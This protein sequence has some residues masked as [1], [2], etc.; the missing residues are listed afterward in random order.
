MKLF[1]RELIAEELIFNQTHLSH[2]TC[3]EYFFDEVTISND[4]S[5]D[6]DIRRGFV[7]LVGW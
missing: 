4:L 6:E 1:E 3:S 5:G 2:A 7:Y